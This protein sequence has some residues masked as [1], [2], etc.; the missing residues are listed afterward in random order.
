[1]NIGLAVITCGEADRIHEGDEVTV[2]TAT[3]AVSNRT[4]SESYQAEPLPPF[5][6]QIAACGGILEYIRLHGWEGVA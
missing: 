4:R 1:M 5:V 6:Q 3:G 2:N